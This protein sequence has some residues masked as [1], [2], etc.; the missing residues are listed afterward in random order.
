MY[1]GNRF[2][3]IFGI[4]PHGEQP[5]IGEMLHQLL[6]RS[7]I[8]LT[9]IEIRN[10]TRAQRGRKSLLLVTDVHQVQ[11]DS[12]RKKTIVCIDRV[13]RACRPTT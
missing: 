6:D 12:T 11:Q 4:S 10:E 9:T 2:Q 1:E 3:I 7:T 13:V 8:D 5:S